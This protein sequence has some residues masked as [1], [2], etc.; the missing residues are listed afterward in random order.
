M[1]PIWKLLI[2]FFF[3]KKV[4]HVIGTNN[5]FRA[6][7]VSVKKSI[8]DDFEALTDAFS[9]NVAIKTVTKITCEMWVNQGQYHSD[10]NS[11]VVEVSEITLGRKTLQEAGL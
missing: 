4:K 1:N 7:D 5:D 8:L 2:N 3:N 10:G 9:Y 11:T 6:I